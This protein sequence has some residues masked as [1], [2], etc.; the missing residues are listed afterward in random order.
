M[1]IRVYGSLSL[2]LIAHSLS[3]GIL[4]SRTDKG[5]QFADAAVITVNGKDKAL[6]L[7]PQTKVVP[8]AQQ[9]KLGGTLL[10]DAGSNVIGHYDSDSGV[11]N[12]LLPDGL[13]NP[14]GDAAPFW[15]TARISL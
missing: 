5:L 12:F 14:S 8:K 6:G 1:S 10:K 11:M 9:V 13:K 3:G 15:K 4:I 2:I 7:G